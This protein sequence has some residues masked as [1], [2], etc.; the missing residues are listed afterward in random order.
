MGDRDPPPQVNEPPPPDKLH[1]AGVVREAAAAYREN[2]A[3][4]LIMAVAVFVP[5]AV[6]EAATHSLTEIETDDGLAIAATL[7]ALV[8]IAATITLGDIFFTGIV[9]AIVGARRAGIGH[10][11]AEVTRSLRYG[12]LLGV[13]ILFAL[14]LAVGFLLLIVPGV[15]A[16]GWFALAAPVVEIE[17][18]RVLDSFRRSRRLVRGNF[19][20]VMALLAPVI[21]L[22]DGLG[23]F[24]SASGPWLLGDGF[25]GDVLGSFLAELVAVPLFALIAVVM[26][27]HLIDRAAAVAPAAP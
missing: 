10:E 8:V 6:L 5:I 14:A 20:R 15:L 1:L 12:R 27:H 18:R 26:T 11:L 25:A 24:L 7:G 4:L 21:L 19:W 2:A 22:G 9:A 23:S 3:V 16:F 17:D 13:D